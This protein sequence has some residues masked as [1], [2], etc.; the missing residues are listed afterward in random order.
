MQVRLAS[1]L[2]ALAALLVIVTSAAASTEN[3]VMLRFGPLW[4]RELLNTDKPTA[5]NVGLSYGVAPGRKVGVGVGIDFLWN[6]TV[7]EKPVTGQPG[8]Y[9]VTRSEQSYMFPLSLFF[10]L[11]PI[12][13]YVVHPAATLNVGYNSMF[14]SFDD[15]QE[16]DSGKVSDADPDGYYYGLYVKL[17]L[18]ALVN[19]GEAGAFFLGVDYQWANTRSAHHDGNTYRR[20]DMSGIGIRAG[21][22]LLLGGK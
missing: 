14:Y 17:A 21:F 12:E 11:D 15:E 5:W 4:P 2:I 6:R 22:R 3:I 8:L 7:N 16:L 1:G 20:R 18:D 13:Q 9:E 19:I 10:Y